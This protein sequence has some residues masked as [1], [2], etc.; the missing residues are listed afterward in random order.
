MTPY[1]QACEEA[2]MFLCRD[3][4]VDTNHIDEYYMVDFA[5]W[6]EHGA[7]D[8]MLCIGCL[9]ARIGRRLTPDDFI[10]API[11]RGVFPYSE[12]L[13]DRLFNNSEVTK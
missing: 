2:I 11:N 3:C 12:R 5:L 13:V 4:G 1:E 8:G 6:D 7:G 9:E 10:D